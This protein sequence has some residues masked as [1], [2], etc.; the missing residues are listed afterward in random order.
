MNPS[1]STTGSLLRQHYERILYPYDIF[2]SGAATGMVIDENAEYDTNNNRMDID[3]KNHVKNETN[4]HIT[5]SINDNH[6]TSPSNKRNLDNEDEDCEGNC[7]KKGK[8]GRTISRRSSARLNN[9]TN[10]PV[11]NSSSYTKMMNMNDAINNQNLNDVRTPERSAK[12]F[13]KLCNLTREQDRSRRLL[14]CDNCKDNFHLN[15][16]IIPLNSV[17]RGKWNC[18]KCV[19][20]LVP[21][22]PKLYTKEFGF[23]ESRCKYTLNE[24]K[25]ASDKFK[26]E[27]FDLELNEISCDLV[28]K[29]FWRLVTLYEDVVTVEYGADLHTNLVS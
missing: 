10:S 15:C 16:L 29:E 24:F 12:I 6:Q 18:P 23:A 2:V 17:P 14:E 1:K 28:E 13:C 8:T 3:L 26:T 11:T 9:L 5:T 25:E 20:E 7:L 27:Y 19:A 22:L 21:K 4:D